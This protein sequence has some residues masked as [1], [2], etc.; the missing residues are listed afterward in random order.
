M[1]EAGESRK[2]S[3][4]SVAGAFLR[5]DTARLPPRIANPD[6]KPSP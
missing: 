4:T 6:P 1:Q 5:G 3:P 2:A